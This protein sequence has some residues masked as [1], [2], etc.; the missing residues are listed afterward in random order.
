[1]KKIFIA[2]SFVLGLGTAY[3]QQVQGSVTSKAKERVIK[4]EQ[5][6]QSQKKS[7]K[8]QSSEVTEKGKGGKEA[9]ARE[10]R[11]GK[12]K[13]DG[14]PDRRYKENRKLKKDGTPDKRFK[15]RKNH[16]E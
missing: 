10:W 9:F 16:K 13:A 15:S 5:K 14:T 6:M 2:M 11:K 7:F 8:K 3:S 4:K 1:M 12:L